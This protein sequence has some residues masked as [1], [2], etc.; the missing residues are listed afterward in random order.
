MNAAQVKLRDYQFDG[1]RW[2]RGA[3]RE[4]RRVA[5]QLPTGGGKTII[6]GH[7]C[8]SIVRRGKRAAILVHRRELIRQT[9]EKL[10]FFGVQAG[11]IAAGWSAD[12]DQPIQVASVQT[13]VRRLDRAPAADLVVLDE[14]HHAVAG[15]WAAVLEHYADAYLLG[16]T[17]TP[18]RLDGKG[19]ADH[20][21]ILVCGPSVC[22]LIAGGWLA[23]VRVLTA[24]A[25]DL[26]GIKRLGG[27][28]AIGELAEAMSDSRLIGDA[29][30]HYREHAE[31]RPAIAFCVTIRHAELVAERFLAAG[32]HA[33][34]V[35]GGMAPRARDAV[36]HGLASGELDVVTSCAL[37]S[38][39]LDVPDVGAALL[40][41]PTQSLTL[42]L[43]QIGRALRPKA[44]GR[45][46]V[47]LD[48][49]GNALRHGDPTA[50]RRWS[51]EGRLKRLTAESAERE[52][53]AAAERAALPPELAGRLVP[54]GDLRLDPVLLRTMPLRRALSFCVT[55]A[56][57]R[58]L[59]EIRGYKR[60]WVF[61]VLRE[62]AEA[63]AAS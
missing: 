16:V 23:D 43:Q 58:R 54:L 39:G 34:S 20:F 21:D 37:I 5:F 36:I 56:D 32:Y 1:V 52:R 18:E 29:V 30:A 12:P 48:H 57:I 42:Y 17:A 3:M 47:I 62:R 13:L 9:L 25:P 24:R 8:Q 50:P 2:V 40:L 6:F 26:T 51:L 38:E 55:E 15:T 60:G 22:D 41:R 4:H 11:V 61:H 35:D 14:A 46:A 27:D 63:S 28:Y 49:A 44:D 59:G 53:E 7:I 31:G 10:S 45:P 19:L 33:A